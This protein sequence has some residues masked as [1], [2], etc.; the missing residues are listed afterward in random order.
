MLKPV[1][2]W[3]VAL[4]LLILLLPVMVL[5]AIALFSVFGHRV[6][7][8][9]QRIGKHEK[10]FRLLKFRTMHEKYDA[11]GILLPDLERQSALGNFLRACHLDEL[12]QLLNILKG[13]LAL[14]GPRPLL[15]EYLPYYSASQ[16]KRHHVCPGLTGLAQ[17]KGG[18]A[19][20]W[21]QRLR[22][23]CFYAGHA[24]ASLDLYILRKTLS[25]IFSHRTTG[26]P[27]VLFSQSFID[28]LAERK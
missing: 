21:R 12:P 11:R 24:S 22:Y 7:F 13:E 28:Y 5:V 1:I 16:R 19:L 10:V 20:D 8:V 3:L 18:N 9:Q 25:Y 14:I 2:S 23:D 26:H 27:E 17:I 4:V 6:F 15:V